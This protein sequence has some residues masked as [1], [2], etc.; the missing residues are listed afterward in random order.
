M[1]QFFLFV[2]RSCDTSTCCHRSWVTPKSCQA[3]PCMSPQPNMPV[4]THIHILLSPLPRTLCIYEICVSILQNVINK[5][6]HHILFPPP[7][8]CFLFSFPTICPISHSM[9]SPSLRFYFFFLFLLFSWISFYPF[10]VCSTST[11]TFLNSHCYLDCMPQ[12]RTKWLAS[13][14]CSFC[15]VNVM[16]VPP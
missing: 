1:S 4:F 9:T 14:L 16:F 6:L 3:G 10:L 15:V 2:L 11:L 12:R 5:C 8:L 13:F 7:L